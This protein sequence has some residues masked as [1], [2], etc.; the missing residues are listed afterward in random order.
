[1]TNIE[2][3][4]E[5][6]RRAHRGQTDNTGVD[7]IQ[8][9]IA[10]SEKVYTEDTKVVALLHD[11]LEDTEVSEATIYAIWDSVREV[12]KDLEQLDRDRPVADAIYTVNDVRRGS[13]LKTD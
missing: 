5:F 3:T 8:H 10:V 9:P 6:A 11:V 12:A 7:Y 2:F 4:Q 13:T 1:L